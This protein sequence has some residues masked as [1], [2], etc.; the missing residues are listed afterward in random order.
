[1]QPKPKVRKEPSE[2]GPVPPA[3]QEHS[4]GIL[5]ISLK[6]FSLSFANMSSVLSPAPPLS[7]ELLTGATGIAVV[8]VGASTDSWF[9][10][11]MFH[12]V[13]MGTAVGGRG[14]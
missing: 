11:K 10:L 3:R 6:N 1:M 7:V 4:R 8:V 2:T 5:F 9:F 13:A 14:R 12:M